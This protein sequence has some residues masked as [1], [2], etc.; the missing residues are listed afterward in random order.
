MHNNSVPKPC[1]RI[2]PPVWFL[3]ALVAMV[4]LP[5]WFPVLAILPW[6]WNLLGSVLILLGLA[7]TVIADL[8]FKRLRT[9]VKPYEATAVLV[10]DGV[11]R[12]SRNPMYLGMTT[13]LAGLA[14]CLGSM[15][16]WAVVLVF[17]LWLYGCF[18]R[19]EEHAL[20]AR[21]AAQFHAY[22]AR[23]RCWI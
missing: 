11:F 10:T 15:T 20:A 2:L 3:A 7:V 23:T 1:S 21:F 8:Q 12:W 5:V 17:P 22:R 16:C 6:P 13:V 18:I 14:V 4:V 9:T 19:A